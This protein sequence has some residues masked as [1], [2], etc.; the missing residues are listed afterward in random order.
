MVS[1]RRPAFPMLAT[2]IVISASAPACGDFVESG[3]DV[4]RLTVGAEGGTLTTEQ[5]ALIVPPHSL[6]SPVTLTAERGPADA[7]ASHAYVV[8]PHQITFDA[9]I[10]AEVTIHYDS[11]VHTHPTEVFAAV[12]TGGVWHQL[13][14]PT[15]DTGTV[16][17]ARGVT[18]M[19]GTFGAIECPGGV[20]P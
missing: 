6:T 7:P 9:T 12:Q 20:C 15:G 8:G 13:P 2:L 18:T 1:E 17:V 5:L 14:R 10:P 19:T 4:T 3:G 11:A 16:G